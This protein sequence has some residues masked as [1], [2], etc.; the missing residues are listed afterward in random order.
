MQF[1]QQAEV[2][3]GGCQDRIAFQ[4]DVALGRDSISVRDE[5]LCPND[6]LHADADCED[7]RA[8][9]RERPGRESRSSGGQQENG[10]GT[11]VKADAKR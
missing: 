8:A 6:V 10:V 9:L 4:A 2:I 3:V 11:G 5:P 1:D 7:M